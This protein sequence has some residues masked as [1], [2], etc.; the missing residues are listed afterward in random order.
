MKEKFVRTGYFPELDPKGEQW[1][2]RV[3]HDPEWGSTVVADEKMA[4]IGG[5]HTTTGTTLQLAEQEVRWLRDALNALVVKWDIQTQ[6]ALI[7]EV[8]ACCGGQIDESMSILDIEHP[9]HDCRV[10]LAEIE[11]LQ[12]LRGIG[13]VDAEEDTLAE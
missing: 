8:W 2:M 9:C 4:S 5:Q 7:A 3:E 13:Q 10:R 1:R 12:A 6:D 11:R